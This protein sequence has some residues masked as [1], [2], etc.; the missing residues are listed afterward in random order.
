M[1]R[2]NDPLREV[3]IVEQTDPS[4]RRR[5]FENDYF[6]LFVWQDTAGAVTRF[7]LCYDVE[8]NSGR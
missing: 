3:L 1:K 6:D 7:E 5:W 2:R 4:L 8:L